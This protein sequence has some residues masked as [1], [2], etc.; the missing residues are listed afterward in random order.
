M[1]KVTDLGRSSALGIPAK[2]D[3][4][5]CAGDQKYS[6]FEQLYGYISGDWKIRRFSCDMYMFGNL[7]AVYFNNISMTISVLNTLSKNFKAEELQ[8]T[9]LEILPRLEFAFSECIEH[10]NESLDPELR[11]ELIPM[12]RQLCHPDINKRGDLLNS[13]SPEKSQQYS[14]RRYISRLDYLVKKWEY[15]FKQVIK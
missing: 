8:G 10:F 15:K 13:N 11:N 12:V 2:H 14:L 3:E 7:I 1:S 4:Y 6:P 5:D 9:Y